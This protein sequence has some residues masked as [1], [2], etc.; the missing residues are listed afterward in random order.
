MTVDEY[1]SAYQRNFP[2]VVGFFVSRGLSCD[3]AREYVQAAWAKGWERKEQLRNPRCLLPWIISIARNIYLTN[4]KRSLQE[5]KIC[6][7]LMRDQFLSSTTLD[8]QR[9]LAWSTPRSR[10]ILEAYYVHGLSVLEIATAEN[11]SQ[12]A[13][14]GRLA[15]ARKHAQQKFRAQAL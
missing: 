4:L 15:R 11:V 2:V 10:T 12:A 13:V 6:R 14:N 7:R 9:I 3:D 8:S 1:A 5:S